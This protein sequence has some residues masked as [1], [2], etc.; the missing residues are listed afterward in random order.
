[1][2]A[3]QYRQ[4]SSLFEVDAIPRNLNST[5]G[6][7]I[8][9]YHDVE[10]AWDE[11]ESGR[12]SIALHVAD[13]G[14]H[15]VEK[16]NKFIGA[17]RVDR[18]APGSTFRFRSAKFF[19]QVVSDGPT[20]VLRITESVKTEAFRGR[21]DQ[22]EQYRVDEHSVL[23]LTWMV[24]VKL[25][26]GIGISLVDWTPQELVYLRLEDIF[27][28]KVHGGTKRTL[29]AAIGRIVANNQLW[30]TPYPVLLRVGLRSQRRRHRRHSAVALSWRRREASGTGYGNMTMFE[31]IELS[32][33]PLTVCVDGN[34]T[35]FIIAMLRQIKDVGSVT[36]RNKIG[37]VPRNEVLGQVLGEVQPLSTPSGKLNDPKSVIVDDLYFAGTPE[38]LLTSQLHHISS[39]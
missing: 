9:P 5:L 36:K 2:H 34:L 22:A 31:I 3:I 39:D 37:I 20:R 30:V 35:K 21:S 17:V 10:F 14:D 16:M 32:M 27:F 11:P 1:V 6:P 8:L 15:F 19:G 13:L 25:F 28:E 29:T 38:V 23:G 24:T 4:I 26:H 33:E 7:V 18:I 12:H